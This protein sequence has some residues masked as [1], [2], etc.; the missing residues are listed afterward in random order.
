MQT[1]QSPLSD[2]SSMHRRLEGLCGSEAL[3][4]TGGIRA[5]AEYST[6]W[7]WF[8]PTLVLARTKHARAPRAPFHNMMTSSNGNLFRVTGPLCGEFTGDRSPVNSPH[9][10]QWHGALMFSLICVWINN[11]E[12]GDLR[13]YRT[14]YDAIV[15]KGEG[16]LSIHVISLQWRHNEQDGVSNYLRGS[17]KT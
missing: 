12:A 11:R 3:W 9:K 4:L 6:I 16:S 10:G 8:W 2:H 5:T 17:K 15:M 14:H 13:R 1:L 7:R